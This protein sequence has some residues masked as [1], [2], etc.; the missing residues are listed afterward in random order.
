MLDR[1]DDELPLDD[2]ARAEMVMDSVAA[3]LNTEYLKEHCSSLVERRL[4]PPAF[5]FQLVQRAQS[6]KKRIVLPEGDEPRTIQAAAISQERGIAQC[7]L[8]GQR[9]VIEQVAKDNGIVLPEG[10]IIMEPEAVRSRYVDPMVELRKSIGLTA[11]MAEAQLEDTVV[12]GTMMLAMNE[13]DGL[14]SGAVHTTANTFALH[15]S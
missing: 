7:I 4:S 10:L 3:N 12:L 5:R 15:S 11:P 6:A 1:R 8:L 14:V 2:T 9:S 13:V